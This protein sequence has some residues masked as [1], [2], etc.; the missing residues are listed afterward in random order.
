MPRQGQPSFKRQTGDGPEEGRETRA[1]GRIWPKVGQISLGPLL[2]PR[3]PPAFWSPPVSLCCTPFEAPQS[4]TTHTAHTHTP[5]PCSVSPKSTSS[6]SRAGGRGLQ[7]KAH[8]RAGVPRPVLP[9]R[10]HALRP[11]VSCN[12]LTAVAEEGVLWE[13]ERGEEREAH[14]TFFQPHRCGCVVPPNLSSLFFFLFSLSLL[15]LSLSPSP[16]HNAI[17]P[18]ACADCLAS[19]PS[20]QTSRPP[21]RRTAARSSWRTLSLARCASFFLSSSL[22]R[23]ARPAQSR[24][25]SPAPV[26]RRPCP[27]L[28]APASAPAPCS[29]WA[30]GGK[31][32]TARFSFLSLA[33]RTGRPASFL[34]PRRPVYRGG[35]CRVRV[36]R[37]PA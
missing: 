20:L 10:R 19:P 26:A 11:R 3:P 29:R 14:S 12:G 24:L 9:L 18:C 22:P 17:S 15:S 28:S 33:L 4:R 34:R 31:R 21:R 13:K 35:H 5:P 32:G 1:V 16:A 8:R 6:V 37:M 2:P 25:R 27:T 36:C 30:G 23:I 7:R